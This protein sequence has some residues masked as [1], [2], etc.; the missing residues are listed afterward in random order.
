M[1]KTKSFFKTFSLSSPTLVLN[2]MSVFEPVF[3]YYC[4]LLRSS[5]KFDVQPGRAKYLNVHYNYVLVNGT[6]LYDLID[7]IGPNF[8]S[9]LSH[10]TFLSFLKCIFY[11]GKGCKTRKYNHIMKGNSL[12]RQKSSSSCARFERILDIW[13]RGQAVA[14]IQLADVCHH[15]AMS[16]EFSIIKAVGIN[17]LTNIINSSCYGAMRKWSKIEIS[18]FGIMCLYNAF[19]ST[20]NDHPILWYSH[21]IP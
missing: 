9:L 21:N 14:I 2:A 7:K 11:V 3:N 4:R 6:K 15:E 17:N 5:M 20:L 16:R 12:L 10:T 1:V 19:L 13:N 8:Y 18:N